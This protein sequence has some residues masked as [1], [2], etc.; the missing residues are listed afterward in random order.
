MTEDSMKKK[1]HSP[2]TCGIDKTNLDC[3]VRAAD[4]FYSYACGGWQKSHP[5][6]ADHARFGTFD[7]LL[8]DVRTQLRELIE[9]LDSNPESKIKGTN[10]QKVSDLYKLALD[11]ERRNKEGAT[12]ILPLLKVVNS[13]PKEDIS[14][15]LGMLH[16]GP[17]GGTLFSAANAPDAKN[18]GFYAHHLG[19][20]GLHLGDRDYYLKD[21]EQNNRIMAAFEIFVKRMMSLVGYD[22]QEQ[23]RVWEHSISIERELARHKMTR[24][25]R[26]DPQIQYNPMTIEELRDRYKNID[27]DAYYRAF[28]METPQRIIVRSPAF[29]DGLDKLLSTASEEALRDYL[30]LCTVSDA[31]GALS[32]DFIQAQFDF[33][34]V[35][36]GI[37]QLPPLWKRA[38]SVPLSVLGESVGQLY[39]ERYFPD[40]SKQKMLAIVENLRLALAEHI[41]NLSWMG[42]STKEKALE[43]LAAMTVKIGYPD[44]WKDYSGIEVDP[45]KTLSEN[46]L[47]AA[48]WYVADNLSKLDKPVDKQEWHMTP[49]TVNAYY[50]PLT[51]EIC[52]PAGILQ[53]PYFDPNADDA[54]NYGAIG[55]VIGHEMTHGFDDSGRQYDKDGNLSDWWAQEDSERFKALAD[56]LVEQFDAIE[57]APG[58]NAKGRFTLGENIADQ[59][60]LRIALTAY[61]ASQKRKEAEDI[62][63]FSPLQRFY[64][65]Y[66]NVWADNIRDEEVLLRTQTDSHSLGRNR[67]NATLRNINDFFESFGIKDGDKMFL[68]ADRQII[69]W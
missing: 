52:F 34:R 11:M 1:T 45:Q 43:K 15:L 29:F 59:G 25:M 50:S 31:A 53:P 65:S 64:L 54:L 30:S 4:D 38:M 55:V 49:Q 56:K 36:S 10:A 69:I 62:D 40:D 57:V 67:V 68:P 16:T 20:G 2:K 13:T 61:K 66:A 23:Q 35:I 6:P 5:I 28:G 22:E 3:N 41:R 58:V 51:N 9:G 63:G 39:V 33:E 27:F 19:E 18:S 12:A 47:S 32:D 17:S 48:R 7:A 24:E 37:E 42:E 46:L 44:T 26:R 8:E 14:A 21:N 60:G